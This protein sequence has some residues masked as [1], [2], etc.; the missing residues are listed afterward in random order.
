MSKRK[1]LTVKERVQVIELSDTG[2]SS[3]KIAV[4]FGVGR[5]QVCDIL[6]R[7][8]EILSEYDENY[9]KNRKRIR[10]KLT[11]D[12]I[13][14]LVVQWLD[15]IKDQGGEVTEA[16]IQAKALGFA[17]ELNISPF[18]ASHKWLANFLHRYKLDRELSM[19]VSMD[20]DMDETNGDSSLADTRYD[21]NQTFTNLI[22]KFAEN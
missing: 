5:S 2:L 22:F 11:Y 18:K 16:E 4:E 17:K 19:T 9:H 12:S 7:R 1:C 15:Q 20:H 14:Q 10:P 6:R 8:F 13:N 21:K 3:R